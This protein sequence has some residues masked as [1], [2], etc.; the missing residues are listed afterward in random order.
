MKLKL[1]YTLLVFAFLFISIL[2]AN[3]VYADQKINHKKLT[4]EELEK[5]YLENNWE[6]EW[7]DKDYLSGTRHFVC[8]DV[9]QIQAVCK[10]RSSVCNADRDE[11]TEL[12]FKGKKVEFITDKPNICVD[13]KGA[14]KLYRTTEGNFYLE[15]KY[16]YEFRGKTYNGKETCKAVMK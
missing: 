10:G 9:N 7:E 4:Q 11:I 14:Y 13:L 15:G 6:C 3:N 12:K 8:E 5:I 2:I 1:N 16:R